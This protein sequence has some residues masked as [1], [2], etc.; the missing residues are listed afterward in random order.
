MLVMSTS[1]VSSTHVEYVDLPH[2]HASLGADLAIDLSERKETRHPADTRTPY[3]RTIGLE[4]GLALAVLDV[5]ALEGQFE[6]PHADIVG[7]TQKGR[8][9]VVHDAAA[10]TVSYS[11]CARGH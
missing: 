2:E 1:V 6:D 8:R 3:A 4:G 7:Q 11:H 10:R 5:I 9:V